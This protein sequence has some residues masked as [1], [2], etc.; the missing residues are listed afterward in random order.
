M[1][2]INEKFFADLSTGA[3]WSAGVAFKRSNPL[4]LDRYSV[5]AS[6]AEAITYATTNAV[7]YPGQVIAVVEENKMGVYVLAQKATETKT[8]DE[9]GEEKVEITYSLD[10][11]EISP[12]IDLSE[13]TTFD[14]LE[15]AIEEIVIP[16]IP[17]ITASDDDVVDVEADGHDITV[18]HAKK[19][20]EGG[21]VSTAEADEVNTFGGSASIKVPAIKVDEYGHVSEVAEKEFKV[22]IPALPEDKN[23]EYTL[24]YVTREVVEGDETKTKKYIQLKDNAGKVISEID[25]AEF[26]KDGML[27]DVA[28]DADNNSLTFVWNTASGIATDTVTLTD[29]LDPYIAGAKI[30]INGT[31]ISHV[32]IET[33]D[34]TNGEEITTRKYIAE[35]Q[36]DGYGHIIGYKTAE[37]K[38]VDTDTTYEISVKTEGDGKGKTVI[39]TPSEGEATEATLDVYTKEETYSKTEVNTQIEQYVEKVTGGESAGEV[40][41]K[42]ENYQE[43]IDD[44]IWGTEVTSTWVGQD[45]DGADIYAPNYQAP[46][47]IDTIE[48]KLIGIQAG[49]Q[50]NLIDL[51]D[52]NNFEVVDKKLMLKDITNLSE[53]LNEKLTKTD[54]DENHFTYSEGKLTLVKDYEAGAQVNFIDAVDTAVFEVK[55]EV[56]GQDEDGADIYKATLSL[57]S[58]PATTLTAA[59]GDLSKLPNAATMKLVDEINNIYEILSWGDIA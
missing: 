59:L 1:S 35:I 22:A 26:I 2:T 33:K 8:T 21:F 39:L 3:T 19:G 36:T 42:L 5:F 24:E 25:A 40:L 20:P 56:V 15:K 54:V 7:A 16:Q 11:Q 43:A 9:N 46:S 47:R 41:G 10:L 32:E 12:D 53:A 27:T 45:E 37:E 18:S 48:N 34:N 17:N 28:Y 14:D 55:D 23:T 13:Y 52:E 57:V 38:V 49:A 6:K 51:V 58:V 44:E 29:I 50:V 31:E 30:A 4:P